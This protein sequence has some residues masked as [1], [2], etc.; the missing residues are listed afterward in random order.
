VHKN[1][2][3]HPEALAR[4]E[5]CFREYAAFIAAE[6]PEKIL[7]MATSAARDVKNGQALFDLAARYDI[8]VKIIPG[9]LEADIT[10]RGA[11]FDLPSQEGVAVI[12]VGGGST[13]V[14]AQQGGRLQGHSVDV[15][16]VRLTELYAEDIGKISTHV[17]EAFQ[18]QEKNLP[19]SP[20][21][22]VVAV[23]GTPTTLA[24]VAQAKPYSHD[25]VHGYELSL[26][27][28]KHWRDRLAA[29]SL[30]ERRELPGMDPK[31]ADVIVAGATILI[32]ALEFLKAPSLMVSDYGVRYGVAL[33]M[34]AG[35][36]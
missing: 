36:C 34:E 32:T 29:L 35:T 13:E 31:R 2:E 5:D 26:E 22:K 15:G 10:F 33:M 3:F 21:Q 11:T 8:P 1:R 19:K 16:S 14:M 18:E 24:A 4:A 27:Q 17:R 6:K 25:S 28:L 20:L 30:P 12:D 23:A 9:H 7:A